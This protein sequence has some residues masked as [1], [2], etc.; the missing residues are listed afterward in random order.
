MKSVIFFKVYVLN[1]AEIPLVESMH[2]LSHNVERPE[3]ERRYK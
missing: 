2:H 3:R 1:L